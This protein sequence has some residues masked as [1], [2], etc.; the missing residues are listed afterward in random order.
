MPLFWYVVYI[1]IF[2]SGFLTSVICNIFLRQNSQTL[3]FNSICHHHFLTH[4]CLQ[5]PNLSYPFS[6][7][8]T[9]CCIQQPL[10]KSLQILLTLFVIFIQSLPLS[11]NNANL[12]FPQSQ[13]SSTYLCP[14]QSLSW[15][16]Q[17]LFYTFHFSKNLTLTKKTYP[18]TG[19]Y[20]SKSCF[21]HIRDLRRIR[22][23]LD[24]QNCL[25][26]CNFSHSL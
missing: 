10:L 5:L 6:I 13:I 15:S 19:S 17:K 3:I 8:Q 20:I 18:T 22:N 2:Q 11:S 24:P 16:I 26:Y 23:T 1:Y 7:Q 4:I 14:L 25:H 9:I 12:F 21:S